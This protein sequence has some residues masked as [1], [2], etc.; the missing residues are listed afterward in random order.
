MEAEIAG[1][2]PPGMSAVA[3]AVLIA[4]AAVTSFLT[5]AVGIGGGVVLLAVMAVLVPP[6]ALIPVHGVVQAGSNVGRTLVMRRHVRAAPLL[7]FG[8]GSLG[9]AALGGLIAVDLPP[10]WVR[11]GLGLFIIYAVWGPKPDLG[12][13]GLWFGGG[14]SSFVTMFFGAT[15]PF[16]ATIVKRLELDRLRHVGTFSACMSLQHGIK[17]AAFGILGFAFAPWLPLLAGMIASGFAGTL[18]GRQV[19]VRLQDRRFHR[20]LDVVLTLLAARLV[21]VGLSG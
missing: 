14:V 6:A 16:V 10:A 5:A 13:A 17:I 1:L 15:G 12:R 4:T 19:L 7:A 2:L 21:W 11:I 9:G 8:I 20:I 3:A 18:I